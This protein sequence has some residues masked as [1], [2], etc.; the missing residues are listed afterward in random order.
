[1]T[2]LGADV[3]RALAHPAVQWA[4]CV[5]DAQDGQD[6]EVLAEVDADRTQRTASLGKLVLLVE[7]ARAFAEGDVDPAEPLAPTPADLVADS[8]LWRHLA[9]RTL[10]A[11]DCAVLVGAFSDNLATNVLLRRLGGVAAVA[12]TADLLGIAD[13]ALHGP[14]LDRRGPGDP[15][16]LSTGTA[17]GYATLLRRLHCGTV[18]SASRSRQVLEWLAVDADLSMVASALALDPLCHDEPDRGLRLWHKT[19]TIADVRGDVGVLGG[20]TRTVAYAVLAQWEPASP[21]LRDEALAGMAG[22]GWALRR[23]V[24]KGLDHG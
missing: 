21:H 2:R 8:G 10:P 13:V 3:A 15:P 6:G 7:A 14:V 9:Q 4:A 22:V 18:G 19:G 12:R 11:V 1:M 16:T 5:L 20:P 24:E 17:R 23:H